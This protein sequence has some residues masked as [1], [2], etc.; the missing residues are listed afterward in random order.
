[1]STR[2]IN[3]LNPSID[4]AAAT[5]TRRR[6]SASYD[7]KVLIGR[8]VFALAA[9]GLWEI[10]ARWILDPFWIGQPSTVAV[11]LLEMA[12][13]GDLWWHAVPT[14]GQ[15][16]AGLVLSLVVG[17]PIGLLFASNRYIERVLEPFFLGLY[18]IP[19][20]AL[21]PLFILWFGIGPWSKVVMA[22][23]MVVFVVILNTYEGMRAIDRELIDM[24]RAMRASRG[25]IL[26]KVVLPGIVPWLFASIRVGV[27]LALIGSVVGE[28]LG[29]N[30]GLGWYVER[31]AGRIDIVGVFTGLVLLMVLGMLLNQCV[32]LIEH[33]LLR[34]RYGA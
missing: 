28:L 32:K 19:R 33:R 8:I 4:A 14:V 11:R 16:A 18:S 7:V 13:S 30:R 10:A 15:A 1:M 25:Y 12:E 31:S 24:M 22:F 3:T 6:S 27:G 21:A 26:R 17:I 20:I 9:I 5:V 29:S 34:N 2:E 23:S